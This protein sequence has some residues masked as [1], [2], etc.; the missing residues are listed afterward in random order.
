[1]RKSILAIAA[2]VSATAFASESRPYRQ[3]PQSSYRAPARLAA[4][5]S[6]YGT[7]RPS[8]RGYG[9]QPVKRSSPYQAPAARRYQP[10]RRPSANRCAPPHRAPVQKRRPVTS[11]RRTYPVRSTPSRPTYSRRR[12]EKK[13]E[14]AASASDLYELKATLAAVV[15]QV[16][17]LRMAKEELSM[18][19]DELRSE[20]SRLSSENSML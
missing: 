5:P 19:K 14:P 11:Y 6:P 2:L 4:P 8:D 10:A 18:A 1:M 3:Q 12:P 15:A 13:E 17:E 16:E 7:R 9:R 20:V